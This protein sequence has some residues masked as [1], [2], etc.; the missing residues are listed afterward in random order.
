[1]YIYLCKVIHLIID[2]SLIFSEKF[3]AVANFPTGVFTVLTMEII[4]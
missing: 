4:N 2:L 3:I 1:M